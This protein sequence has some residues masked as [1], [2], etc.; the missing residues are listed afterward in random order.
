THP[1]IGEEKVAAGRMQAPEMKL[2]GR[3]V[4][5]AGAVAVGADGAS[6]DSGVAGRL[7]VDFLD[8]EDH[9]AGAG[10]G[11]GLAGPGIELD[12]NALVKKSDQEWKNREESEEAMARWWIGEQMGECGR[13]SPRICRAP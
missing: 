5:L 13:S 4:E 10:V 7:H 11:V 9:V 12:E 8:A 2:A 3:I 6:I 1:A